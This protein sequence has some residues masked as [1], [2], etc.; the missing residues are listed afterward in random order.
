MSGRSLWLSKGET[1]WCGQTG[2]EGDGNV[3][4][5]KDPVSNTGG[6]LKRTCWV[7]LSWAGGKREEPKVLI[8]V[9]PLPKMVN[10]GTDF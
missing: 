6:A 1:Y 4:M 2:R 10:P 3:R 5:K 9:M 7:T 8:V